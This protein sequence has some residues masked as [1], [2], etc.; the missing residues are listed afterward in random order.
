MVQAA[1]AQ[2]YVKRL[3]EPMPYQVLDPKVD[4]HAQRITHGS[5]IIDRTRVL[6][7]PDNPAGPKALGE[8]C[9]VG[10]RAEELQH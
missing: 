3:H 1:R 2:D 6:V 4:V 9:V 7:D 5:G 8:S 10:I